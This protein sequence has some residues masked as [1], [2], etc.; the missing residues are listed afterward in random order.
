MRPSILH[1][2][3]R[4][5][6]C[7]LPAT[8]NGP[9]SIG[10]LLGLAP[11]VVFHAIDITADA[12]SSYLAI[13]PLPYYRFRANPKICRKAV[14]FL[15]HFQSPR[16]ARTLSGTLPY[17]VRT[18]LTARFHGPARPR[19]FLRFSYMYDVFLNKRIK[20]AIKNH[21]TGTAKNKNCESTLVL[22]H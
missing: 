7:D 21:I 16:G 9:L 4:Q 19:V 8:S 15:L 14:S 5:C 11:G 17:G 6:P 10:C 18:F 13:S 22:K 12:V 1:Y 3:C 2:R 20:K